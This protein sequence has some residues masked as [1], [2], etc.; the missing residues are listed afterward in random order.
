MLINGPYASKRRNKIKKEKNKSFS[1]VI[2]KESK[3]QGKKVNSSKSAKISS[4]SE[5]AVSSLLVFLHYLIHV[6]MFSRRR[7]HL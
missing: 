4:R 7:I 2:T 6:L 1:P 5:E 3:K